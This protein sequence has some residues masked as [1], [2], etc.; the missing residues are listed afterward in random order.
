M[1]TNNRADR[2]LD[3][4]LQLEAPASPPPELLTTITARTSSIR[5]RPAWL[6]RLEGHHVD[7]IQGGRRTGA[8]R[9]GLVLAIIGLLLVAFAAAAY[10]GSRPQNLVVAPTTGPSASVEAT[11]AAAAGPTAIPRQPE[12]GD[13]MPADVAG[14]WWGAGNQEFVYYL[15]A[16]DDYCVRKYHTLQDCLVYGG[17]EQLAAFENHAD[18]VT[19]VD[20][21]LRYFSLPRQDCEGQESFATW[22]RTGDRLELSVVDPGTGSC[23]THLDSPLVLVGTSGAPASAPPL[24]FP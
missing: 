7:V 15:R 9:L 11:A 21:K 6:A 16:G 19:V 13:P 23:F 14:T 10:I 3:V 17:N 18:V 24:K 4:W 1:N 12:P 20:G 2:L 8:P 22:K 5:P